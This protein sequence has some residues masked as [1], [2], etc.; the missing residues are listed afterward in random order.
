M[1]MAGI[2]PDYQCRCEAPKTLIYLGQDTGICLFCRGIYDERLYE[3]RLREH[4]TGYTY[5]TLHDFLLDKDRH[6]RDLYTRR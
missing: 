6:Y 5:E 1:T 3:M 2:H 4:L